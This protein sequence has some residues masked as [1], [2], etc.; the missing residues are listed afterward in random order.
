MFF[1]AFRMVG[2]CYALSNKL[3]FNQLLFHGLIRDGQGRKM[4]KS[5]GNVIDPVDLI[6]GVKLNEL[7]SRVNESNLTDKEKQ[8][9]IKNQEK[10]YPNGIEAV[11]SDAMRLALLI[12]DYKSKY[13]NYF[14]LIF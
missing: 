7:K 5:I 4:S 13:D 12:Q 8:I 9:S 14:Y 2:M 3:P 10:M 11:G 1:W 6:E